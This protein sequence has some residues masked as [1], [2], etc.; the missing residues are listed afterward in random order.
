M[1][2]NDLVSTLIEVSALDPDGFLKVKE[3]LT[4]IGIPC[5]K[6]TNDL[7]ILWQTAHILHKQGKYYIVHFKQLFLLDGKTSKT[8]FTEEDADRVRSI[9]KM[10]SEWG[11]VKLIVPI[12][13]H[14]EKRVCI[15]SYKDKNNWDLRSKYNI[16]KKLDSYYD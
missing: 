2:R 10:L 6:D 14:I 8:D 1:N 11:L 16:G 4:R 7:P 3:T 13:E 15:V 5:R 12:E 9:A